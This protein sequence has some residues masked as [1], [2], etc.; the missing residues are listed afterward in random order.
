MKHESKSHE[1]IEK[2]V[3]ASLSSKESPRLTDTHISRRDFA[4][5]AFAGGL[6]L[7]FGGVL[8]ACTSASSTTSDG[9]SET[10]D[11][12]T[13]TESATREVV[14]AYERTVSV[15]ET[16]ES[17]ATV[18]SG[19]RFVV[20]AGAQD[21]LVA[22]TEMDT[23]ASANRPYTVVYADLFSEL[24]TTSNGNHLMETSVDAEA[25]LEIAPDVIVSSRSAEECDALQEQ[26]GIPVIGISYQDQLFTDDVYASIRAVG[27]AL[28]T[29]DH[30]EEVI[31]TMQGW[32]DDLQERTADIPDEEKPT[33]YAGAVNY[34]GARSFDGT[35][36]GYAPF[37]AVNALNV[38]DELG[39]TG[40]VTIDIE[41]LA[42][43]D[44]DYMFLNAG[45]ADLMEEDY[46]N[47]QAF[48]DG[49]SA[50]Q[51]GNLYTQPSYNMNGTNIEVG[52][53]NA[54]FI[55]ATIYPDRFADIDLA[56]MYDEIFETLLGQ[57][58]YEQM[59]ELGMDFTSFSIG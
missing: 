21:K 44:P 54:Y 48:F 39:Q 38:V 34:Q 25:L 55:G 20:Y 28:G 40:A 56:A 3:C 2:S 30:A 47:N 23:P 35:Y 45:N 36:A 37:D 58:Y 22:V 24:P 12:S 13:Q 42:V 19:A 26:I 32:Y 6:A 43:W 52:I 8:S 57:P 11:S 5:F 33:V 27:D 1:F 7:S 18:G 9:G 51:N 29:L 49:L 10:E 16:V 46:A 15:P 31:E 4:K 17:V 41:Q 14:D 59:K 53:C 50:F